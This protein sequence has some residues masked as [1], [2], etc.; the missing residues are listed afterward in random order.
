MLNN[1]I[2]ISRAKFKDINFYPT[3][4][5]PQKTTHAFISIYGTEC[6]EL[7]KPRVNMPLWHSGIF[8]QFDDV[9]R[10]FKEQIF[11]GYKKQSLTPISRE[12]AKEIIEYVNHLQ[13]NSQSLKL[14]IHCYAGISRSAAVGKFINDYYKMRLPQ[15]EKLSLYNKFVYRTL[16]DAAIN[17]YY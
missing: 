7:P 8:V 13:E 9:D 4:E 14:I 1:V 17:I 12:Q 6:E 3:R 10:Y 15:Y 5:N 2:N 16:M 11:N